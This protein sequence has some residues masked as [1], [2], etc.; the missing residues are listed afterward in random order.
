MHKNELKISVITVVYNNEK[1]LERTIKS[2][3]NQGYNNLE[4]IIID[5]GSTDGTLDII[6]KHEHEIDYWISEPDEGIYDAMN[7]GIE[8]AT[9]ELIGIINS[10]DWYAEDTVDKVA[11]AYRKSHAD[12]IYGNMIVVDE[13]NNTNRLRECIIS[14]E[15]KIKDLKFSHPTLFVK[16]SIYD[17]FGK[18][19][20]EFVIEADMDFILRL[21]NKDLNFHKVESVFAHFTLGGF[22]SSYNISFNWKRIKDR[23]KILSR[24][25][26]PEAEK[27]NILIRD[28]LR[29][30][31][32]ALLKNIGLLKYFISLKASQY[33]K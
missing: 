9:G 16:K 14:V 13:K 2:V 27:W 21:L 20:T 15:N 19:N 4:Y 25:D 5:G 23:Y 32:K 24:N 7:K 29:F 6:K 17:R 8:Q 28:F 3:V 30:N 1:T 18:F 26:T 10:D 31:V 12:V 33:P 11:Q 22:S